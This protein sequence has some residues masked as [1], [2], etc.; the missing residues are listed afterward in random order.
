MTNSF[1]LN[2]KQCARKMLLAF[3]IRALQLFVYFARNNIAARLCLIELYA[4]RATLNK[5]NIYS[6]LVELLSKPALTPTPRTAPMMPPSS[7]TLNKNIKIGKQTNVNICSACAV[8]KFLNKTQR[9]CYSPGRCHF[10]L[11][12]TWIC[13]IIAYVECDATKNH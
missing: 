7:T 11:E 6:E 13:P 8:R 1:V 4:K 10:C 9:V 5:K 3:V 12:N 2:V